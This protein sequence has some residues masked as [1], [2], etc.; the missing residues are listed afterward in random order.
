LSTSV[1]WILPIGDQSPSTFPS[2][3]HSPSPLL[4]AVTKKKPIQDQSKEPEERK[5]KKKRKKKRPET[6]DK[7]SRTL[8]YFP[9]PTQAITPDH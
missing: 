3:P 8:S 1:K 5:K 9:L 4:L 7:D 6:L 2:P